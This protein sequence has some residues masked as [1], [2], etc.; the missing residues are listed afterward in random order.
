MM[1]RQIVLGVFCLML[2]GLTIAHELHDFCVEV[3]ASPADLAKLDAQSLAC[4]C[5]DNSAAAVAAC[6]TTN[7]CAKEFSDACKKS[8]HEGFCHFHPERCHDLKDFCLEVAA[9]PADLAKLDA[10]SLA[11]ICGDSAPAAVA[12][13]ATANVCDKEFSDACKKSG[14][15]GL[16]HFHPEHKRCH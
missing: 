16:C 14:H 2:V 13:C 7:A 15:E 9:S 3:A 8:G 1:T 5:G 10:Q 12:A 11:C 6:A 4:I